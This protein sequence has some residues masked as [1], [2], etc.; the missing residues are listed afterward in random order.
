MLR[1]PTLWKL[2]IAL[3]T[4]AFA[5]GCASPDA[6][7]TDD[8]EDLGE[9]RSALAPGC[10][11]IIRGGAGNVFDTGLSA[12]NG[13]W[14]AGNNYG[15]WTGGNNLA[16]YQFDLSPVPANAN[17]TSSTLDVYVSWNSDASPVNV[18]ETNT[19]WTE[20]TAKWSNMGGSAHY[21]AQVLG[22]F[23][24]IWGANGRRTVSLTALTRAWL[25]GSKANNGIML[26]QPT[27][28]NHYFGTS[29]GGQA[30]VRPSLTVCWDG[31]INVD[32]CAPNPCQNGGTCTDGV[33]SYTCACP[34]GWTGTNCELDVDDC[35]ANPCQNGGTCTDGAN[36][37]TCACPAG[38][39]GANCEIVDHCAGDPC[40]VNTPN[41]VF[42]QPSGVSCTN[43][44]SGYT[45]ECVAPWFAGAS[46]DVMCPCIDDA[47]AASDDNTVV[48]W[49]ALGGGIGLP[50]IPGACTTNSDGTTT[51]QLVSNVS[52]SLSPTSC[53]AFWD[54]PGAPYPV[55]SADEQT[56][57]QN[58]IDDYLDRFNA[59]CTLDNCVP[60]PCQNGGTCTSDPN[61]YTCACPAGWTGTNCEVDVDECA[62]GDPCHIVTPADGTSLPGGIAC[63]NTEGSFTCECS[64]F[65]FGATCDTECPCIDDALVASDPPTFLAWYYAFLGVAP[66]F[67]CTTDSAGGTTVTSAFFA[68][69]NKITLNASSC[70]SE[71]GAPTTYAMGSPG[72]HA[73]CQ[74]M[75][76]TMIAQNGLTCTLDNCGAAPC[77][78]GGTCTADADGYT[79]ACPDGWTGTN[80]EVDVD[81]CA[82]GDPCNINSALGTGCTNTPGSFTCQCVSPVANADCTACSSTPPAVCDNDLSNIGAGD[83][84]IQFTVTTSQTTWVA[85]VSQRATCTN[86][87]FWDIRIVNHQ[88]FAETDDGNGNYTGLYSNKVVNDGLPHFVVVK[89]TSG[90]LSIDI[91]CQVD[92][93][94]ASAAVIGALPAFAESTPCVSDGTEPLVGT[95][96][97][98]CVTH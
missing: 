17:V 95:L 64:P 44:P 83:F 77:Q 7:H 6:G 92:S 5:A 9:A 38:F 85:L 40:N 2:L 57:C 53:S 45:C 88:I 35:A 90:V 71:F 27:G 28:N 82:A 76:D 26:V 29:E 84:R 33:N 87:M 16:A 37:Y 8:A 96:T 19:A 34:A 56:A 10:V 63:T 74:Q 13:N 81:E 58:L 47:I 69:L 73:A 52:V 24:P 86:G 32:D 78:H 30:D 54:V 22:S 68:G 4:G 61:G 48:P 36:S 80:C 51:V 49:V 89:R 43:T 14:A 21:D 18:H 1:E 66:S 41:P 72:D 50:P 91:D 23:N 60:Q 93:S 65:A 20:S 55:L 98:L 11:T 62:E 75:L 59:S 3:C 12:G 79:C 31:E 67:S 46:C 94:A 25:D 39:L 42:G 70:S 15:A 97:D